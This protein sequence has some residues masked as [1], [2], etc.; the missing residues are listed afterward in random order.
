MH[1]I[2]GRTLDTVRY[3]NNGHNDQR[4]FS[5]GRWNIAIIKILYY[6]RGPPEALAVLHR[7]AAIR[8][9]HCC[10][11]RRPSV[12]FFLSSIERVLF[13]DVRRR[14]TTAAVI[15]Y[16]IYAFYRVIFYRFYP[17]SGDRVQHGDFGKNRLRPF[18]W[19]F[20]PG[21]VRPASCGSRTAGFLDSFGNKE[22]RT[23]QRYSQMYVTS[24]RRVFIVQLRDK[25]FHGLP[26][27][28]CKK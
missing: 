19:L 24:G 23:I 15:H 8:Y 7:A 27:T 28:N 9:Y 22:N 5:F 25:P 16:H 6:R 12:F 1:T 18:I 10:R 2:R 26:A 11:F 13:A 3:N 21:R 14:V 4:L 20:S 17:G